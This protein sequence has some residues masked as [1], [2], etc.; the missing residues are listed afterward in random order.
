MR[1]QQAPVAEIESV[2]HRPRGMVCGD[3]E[4][5][6]VVPVVFDL[7]TVGDREAAAAK[8]LF[9]AATRARDRMQ[10]AE[11]LAPAR[12]RDVDGI[13]GELRRKLLGFERGAARIQRCAQR[14][15]RF[16]DL[17]AR[18]L[19]RFGIH[20]P[21]RLEL[22]GDLAFLAEQA[23]PNLLQFLDVG[24]ARDFRARGLNERLHHAAFSRLSFAFCAITPN[25]AG[26]FMAMSASTL[27]SISSP[28]RLRPAISLLY[29]KPCTRASALMRVIHSERMLR[30]LV[31]RSR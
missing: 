2:V 18:G 30:L 4:R 31:L 29:D 26:S 6:E 9:D 19:A 5:F 14:F 25:A 27:R 21:E 8:D 20:R 15:L 17:R 11:T 22:R 3:V 12:Q 28:A 23:D 13:A 16:I 7:R 1:A 24:R 10:P